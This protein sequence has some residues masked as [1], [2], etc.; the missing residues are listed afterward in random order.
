M[1]LTSKNNNSSGSSVLI[2]ISFKE[3]NLKQHGSQP[4]LKMDLHK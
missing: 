2:I 3:L 4:S 1:M